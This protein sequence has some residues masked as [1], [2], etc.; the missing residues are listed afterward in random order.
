MVW[1]EEGLLPELARPSS[2]RDDGADTRYSHQSL[3][4][5]I[6]T[7]ER[8]NLVGDALDACVEMV[9]VSR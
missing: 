1:A 8:F 9:S 3:A 2:P 6:L 4:V 5:L 7:G